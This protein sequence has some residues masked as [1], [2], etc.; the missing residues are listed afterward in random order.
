MKTRQK[1]RAGIVFFMFLMFPVVVNFLSPVLILSGASEGIITGSFIVF[2]LLFISS[3][4]LGRAWCGWV[5]PA[6]GMHEA[7]EKFR[8]K[9][10]GTGWGNIFR[11][12]V[13]SA[14]LGFIVYM[15]IRAGG[16]TKLDPLYSTESIISILNPVIVF[17]YL[18]VILLVFI[19]LM[20]FGNRAFCKYLCWMA[21]FMIIGDKIRY[22]LKIPGLYIKPKKEKCIS[23]RKCSK[24]C[25]M[26]IE[27]MDMV[28]ADK[29][30]N[31]ECLMCL[32]CVDT[33]PT[34]AIVIKNKNA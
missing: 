34:G 13:W 20:I 9:K 3:L 8:E 29:F 28:Q 5:C 32:R 31:S 1:V 22:R 2:I 15:F 16:I 10:A 4:F 18:G 11:I 7:C 17:V 14:W 25:P 33:C 21:P 27:V 12:V 6:S 26:D 30:Q 19:M 24:N 23:C